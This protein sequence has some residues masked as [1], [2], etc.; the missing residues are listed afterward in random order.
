MVMGFVLISVE[1][2]RELECY[3]GLLKIKGVS[4]VVPI[5]GDVDFLLRVEADTSDKIA[6][7]VLKKIRLV[8]GVF[9]TKTLIEDEF[10]KHFGELY[11]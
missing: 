10:V 5:L 11:T 8:R 4:E 7:I 9:S 1:P 2:G 6:Q 3:G